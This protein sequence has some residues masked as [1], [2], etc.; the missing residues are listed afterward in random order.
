MEGGLLFISDLGP[1]GPRLK[2]D[3]DDDD[4]LIHLY[5]AFLSGILNLKVTFLIYS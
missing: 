1:F 4:D 5:A 3:D 2:D